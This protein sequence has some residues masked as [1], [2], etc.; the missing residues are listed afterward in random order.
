M[1]IKYFKENKHS[2]SI[3][4]YIPNFLDYLY[5][6]NLIKWLHI[7]KYDY[8]EEKITRLQKWYQKDQKYFC[9]KWKKRFKKWESN[10]IPTQIK[11]LQ[12]ILQQFIEKINLKEYNIKVPKFNSCLV[13][14]YRNGLDYI[15][16]H[17]DTALSFGKDPVIAGI[18]LGC[19]RKI[20]FKRVNKNKNKNKNLNFSFQLESGSLFLMMGSSQRFWTHSITKSNDKDCRYSFTFREYI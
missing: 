20:E 9:T 2:D 15:K 6:K 7:L 14:K 4:I 12:K 13:N 8:T 1:E 18:S 3:F 16:H 11:N 10:E 5:Q 19:T 17:R